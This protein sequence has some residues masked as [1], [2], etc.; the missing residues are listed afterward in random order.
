MNVLNEIKVSTD[1][2]V[3]I[4]TLSRQIKGSDV[5]LDAVRDFDGVVTLLLVG[6]ITDLHP[7]HLCCAADP[8]LLR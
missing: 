7:G 8:H 3:L 2:S 1:K 5:S 4:F 6:W